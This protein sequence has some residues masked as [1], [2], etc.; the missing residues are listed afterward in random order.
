MKLLLSASAVLFMVGCVTD[1][2]LADLT[3]WDG[4]GH[5]PVEVGGADCDN[6]DPTV[7]P[8]AEEI[9]GDGLDNDCDGVID[10]DGVGAGVFY[11]DEDQDGAG[12]DSRSATGCSAPPGY[13]ATAGD[14]DDEDA[15]IRPLATERCDGIDNDCDQR[16]DD[17]D[18][19]TVDVPVWYA[20][21]DLD[22][23]G[24]DADVVQSCEQPLGYTSQAGDCDDQRGDIHPGA[25]EVCDGGVDNDCDLLADDDDDVV[26]YAEGSVLAWPDDDGDDYGD[27][28]T[29]AS[30]R[31]EIGAGQTDQGGDCD[32]VDPFVNPDALEV[33][34]GGVDNDC[35][36]VADDDDPGVDPETVLSFLPDGDGD[37]YGAAAGTPVLSCAQPPMYVPDGGDC[38]DGDGA[39]HPGATEVCGGADDDCDG[40]VDDDDDTLDPGAT[41]SWYPDGD[42]DGF[43]DEG[44]V[45]QACVAPANHSDANGDCDDGDPQRHPAHPEICD[46]K[47]N[48]C[49]G[50]ADDD[51]D[52]VDPGSQTL[53]YADADGDGFGADASATYACDRPSGYLITG[54]DCD[55]GAYGVN[56]GGVEVCDDSDTDEDC[57]GLVDDADPDLDPASVDTW[58]TDGDGDG[59]GD[60]LV[61]G[62]ASCES[63]PAAALLGGDCDDGDATV[64]PGAVELCATAYDDDCD[65]LDGDADPGGVSDGVLGY[66]DDDR[67]GYGALPV[68]VCTYSGSVVAEGDDCDDTDVFVNPG[69]TEVCGDGIDNDCDSDSDCS[70]SGTRAAEEAA[71][72]FVEGVGVG[73]GLGHAAALGDVDGD[74]RVDLAT[75]APFV[76]V[77]S[78]S[79][80]T[81]Y[82]FS[83]LPLG[84]PATAA[85]GSIS[86]VEAYGEVGATL[87]A[88]DVEADGLPDL[89]IGA[90]GVG[91]LLLFADLT[92]GG[93]RTAGAATR[94][95]TG[96]T[97]DFLQGGGVVGIGPKTRL[98]DPRGDDVVVVSPGASGGK[99]WVHLFV[100]VEVATSDA[101][102]AVRVEGDLPGDIHAA[103]LMDDYDGD[104]AADLVVG[105]GGASPVLLDE[106]L[107]ALFSGED[108]GTLWGTLADADLTKVG[109]GPQDF[110]G[111]SVT[112]VG[113]VV[114]SGAGALLVGT[115]AGAPNGYASLLV[116]DGAGAIEGEVR[117]EG[118]GG[119]DG[120]GAGVAAAGDVDGDGLADLLVR[121]TADEVV[122]L[123]H[124][125]VHLV[126][127][128]PIDLDTADAHFTDAGGVGD[129][130]GSLGDLDGDGYD[131]FGIGVLDA[132]STTGQT[133]AGRLFIVPG[134]GM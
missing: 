63:P 60:A 112:D 62:W 77:S 110:F 96:S 1:A 106:G 74:G 31:C 10:D 109:A 65:G 89:L 79:E 44:S 71:A 105:A 16:V 78:S 2:R 92:L 126:G 100:E 32:D 67:D 20:D 102:A 85:T 3:D 56:P 24:D 53:W 133:G 14:C 91:E 41:T 69:A 64:S 43:G 25:L 127:T 39:V 76:D 98:A 61:A 48:D 103:T 68:V 47:D 130:L 123:I 81:V 6:Q 28:A 87:A 22:G 72:S 125:G 21:T 80:G 40:L 95:I 107:V 12:D 49:D 111:S 57:D 88:G 52:S 73:D 8:D 17:A 13:V 86:G 55:D 5:A 83:G 46:A 11:R 113:D 26:A 93:H 37:G 116:F 129:P 132:T 58:Y 51:D 66:K 30:P 42:G 114:G 117:L 23:Y 90:P 54:G 33:C 35:N 120:A 131:D 59:Y 19:S 97:G 118:A 7:H 119:F 50:W 94:V 15:A 128:F 121:S 75:G 38:D 45:I 124:G 18:D 27:A 9:C 99:G 4:D 122:A 101:D 34:D 104:G 36:G 29:A 82:L 84:G 108:L 115:D 134:A 70:W